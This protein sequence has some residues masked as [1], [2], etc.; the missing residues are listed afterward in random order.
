MAK[1]N[2]AAQEKAIEYKIEPTSKQEEPQPEPPKRPASPGLEGWNDLVGQRIEEAIRQGEF[3]NLR[4]HGKPLD[5]R[6]N[7]FVPEG[8]ELAYDI[9]ANNKMAP[10]WIGERNTVLSLIEQWRTGFRHA[11]THYQT[12]AQTVTSEQSRQD[13][14]ERWETQSRRWEGELVELNKRINTLNIQQPLAHLEV[15][16]LRLDDEL[17]RIGAGRVL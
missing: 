12:Q 7:P 14:Q 2:K 11:A 13:L 1:P 10:T 16:K 5:L 4:G 6:R 8:K 15:Y 17:A 9:L 3:D